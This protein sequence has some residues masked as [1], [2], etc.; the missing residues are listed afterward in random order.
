MSNKR[1]Q[2]ENY[3]TV[4]ISREWFSGHVVGENLGHINEEN[5]NTIILKLTNGIL[6][7]DGVKFEF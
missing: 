2:I 3:T 7:S 1:K 5:S 4:A 6:F